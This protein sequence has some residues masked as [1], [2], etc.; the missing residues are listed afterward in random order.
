MDFCFCHSPH[1]LIIEPRR[2]GE[3]NK[4]LIDPILKNS[5]EKVIQSGVMEKG[6][7]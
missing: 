4:T 2:T 5:P 3:H 7:T 1:H 6:I